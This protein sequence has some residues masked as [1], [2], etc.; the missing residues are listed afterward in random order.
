MFFVS[1]VSPSS[2]GLFGGT[3]FLFKKEIMEKETRGQATLANEPQTGMND[4]EM[5]N[6]PRKRY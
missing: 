2:R 4:K 3:T 1:R 5:E 6:G